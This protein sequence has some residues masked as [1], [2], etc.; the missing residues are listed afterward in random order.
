MPQRVPHGTCTM[1]GETARAPSSRAGQKVS[2]GFVSQQ[3]GFGETNTLAES[4]CFSQK[5]C[6]CVQFSD[7]TKFSTGE[8]KAAFN[9]HPNCGFISLYLEIRLILRKVLCLQP[10]SCCGLYFILLTSLHFRC[11]WHRYWE[12]Q[13]R[14]SA[15]LIIIPRVIAL[16]VNDLDQASAL[17]HKPVISFW[18][19]LQEN[20]LAA[21]QDGKT[22]IITITMLH[23]A[24]RW[25]QCLSV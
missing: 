20:I 24:S 4:F 5:A 21:P 2:T 25:H 12:S 11:Q 15:M 8:N 3:K 18:K 10:N 7:T 17:K 9:K 6:F 1:E 14:P 13:W 22:F 16:D 23:L 19:I